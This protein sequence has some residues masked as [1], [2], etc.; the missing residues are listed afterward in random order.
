MKKLAYREP[1]ACP[2]GMVL[3]PAGEFTM[4]S[5]PTDSDRRDNEAK[6]KKVMVKEFCIDKY[7]YQNKKNAIPYR[8]AEWFAGKGCEEQGK[9]LCSEAEWE[10]ACKGTRGFKYPYGNQF[11]PQKCNVGRR[12]GDKTIKGKTARSGAKVDCVSDYG[13][14]DMSGNVWEW[15][16]DYYDAD[17]KTFV[18]KGGSYGSSPEAARCSMRREGM[19]FMRR[20]DIGLRCCK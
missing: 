5:D 7:E 4:G 9:R 13:V 15:V 10:K 11:D 6:N 3:V 19:A 1:G 8:K 18:L 17:A 20:K 12:E 14:Y 16:A 2:E